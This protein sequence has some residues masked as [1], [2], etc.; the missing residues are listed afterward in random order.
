[1]N[2]YSFHQSICGV[3]E[4]KYDKPPEDSLEREL[5][6]SLIDEGGVLYRVHLLRDQIAETMIPVMEI[7]E[8]LNNQSQA[9]RQLQKDL[10]L[11]FK[12]TG[13]GG[14]DQLELHYS[15]MTYIGL[16]NREIKLNSTEDLILPPKLQEDQKQSGSQGCLPFSSI[17]FSERFRRI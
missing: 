5:I 4:T 8:K 13:T 1:M 16:A 17:P 14:Q 15:G 3:R 9:R 6:K 10:D 11:I 12:I 7:N 2:F